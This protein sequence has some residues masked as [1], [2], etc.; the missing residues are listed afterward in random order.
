MTRIKE[1]LSWAQRKLQD[2]PV[3]SF[4]DQIRIYEE[5]LNNHIPF[6]SGKLGGN[7]LWAM[8]TVEFGYWNKFD[9]LW[10]HLVHEAGFFYEGD[11]REGVERFCVR[12]REALPY[13]DYFVEWQKPKEY[14][15]LKKYRDKMPEIIEW[16]GVDFNDPWTKVLKRKKVLVIHPFAKSIEYQ[17]SRRKMIFDNPDCLPEMDLKIIPAVQTVGGNR[18]KRF[19]DWF[20]ALDHMKK[21]AL[22]VDFDIALIGC[23]AYGFPLAAEIKKAGRASIHMGGELQIVFGILG[24]R[25]EGY[26]YIQKCKNEYWKYPY[27]EEVPGNYENVEGGCYW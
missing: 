19:R 13:V 2:Y 22:T 3:L 8:R 10:E 18:D 9:A 17:Y 25:W 21:E 16:L 1:L 11:R 26:S 5:K 6:M 12:F 14:F 4:D 15:F 23:G 7:E 24:K 20:E 27:P